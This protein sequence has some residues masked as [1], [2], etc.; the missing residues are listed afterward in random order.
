[1]I[2]DKVTIGCYEYKIVCTQDAIIVDGRDCRGSIDYRSRTIRIKDD[3]TLD[4][5]TKEQTFYHEVM[6]AIIDYRNINPQTA[7]PETLVD[8]IATG[9]YSLMKSNGN[10]PGQG[11]GDAL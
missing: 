10:L 1:V 4:E 2:P 5:Q 6:H 7:D 3:D 11:A 8:E 9:L